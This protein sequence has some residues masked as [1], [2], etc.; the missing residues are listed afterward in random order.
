[1]ERWVGTVQVCSYAV[2][3][4]ACIAIGVGRGGPAGV[5][6]A[7]AALLLHTTG[8]L[9]IASHFGT[10]DFKRYYATH[11]HKTPLRLAF[12]SGSQLVRADALL[13]ALIP[14]ALV[15]LVLWF[16]SPWWWAGLS[17]LIALRHLVL[18]H[19]SSA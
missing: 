9:V 3:F 5:L 15:C 6:L 19:R 10:R 16:L 7:L 17:L 11:R 4:M 1:M 2:L 14:A 8:N 13:R 12:R 18:R